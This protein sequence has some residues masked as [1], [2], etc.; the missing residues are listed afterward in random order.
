MLREF[1]SVPSATSGVDLVQ[2]L[3]MARGLPANLDRWPHTDP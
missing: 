3:S 2:V 1:V